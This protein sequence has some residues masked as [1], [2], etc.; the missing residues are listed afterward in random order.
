MIPFE[1]PECEFSASIV[2]AIIGGVPDAKR[3]LLHKYGTG[4][5]FL[6]RRHCRARAE[7][8]FTSVTNATI[9]AVVRHQIAAD[10]DLLKLIQSN[11]RRLLPAYEEDLAAQRAQV[12]D[13]IV[14]AHPTVTNEIVQELKMFH[15][16]QLQALIRFYVNGESMAG[17]CA[18]LGLSQSQI[19][20][21]RKMTSQI[22]RSALEGSHPLRLF[23]TEHKARQV[24][25]RK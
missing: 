3:R 16:L 8:F 23:R 6:I 18:D 4:L 2:A 1:N 11:F 14:R 24:A 15:P 10:E 20:D 9:D 7:E 17:I 25:R 12:F 22:V 13:E 19:S 21:T 5:W